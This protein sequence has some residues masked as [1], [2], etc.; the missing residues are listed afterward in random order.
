VPVEG[1]EYV[2]EADQVLVAV[3]QMP[4]TG[5]LPAE[6]EL[7]VSERGHVEAINEFGVTPLPDV[8]V[9]GDV[10]GRTGS[11]IEA[12]ASGR[13]AALAVDCFL[14]G[15]GYQEAVRRWG[16]SVPVDTREVLIRSIEREPAGRIGPPLREAEERAGDFEDVE[17]T[18]SEQDAVREASRCLRCGCG[19]GCELCYR[20]CPYFAVKPDGF[21]FRVDEELC[22]GCGLCIERCPNDNIE[23]VPLQ[24]AGTGPQREDGEK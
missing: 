16:E 23:A 6:T 24:A 10:T 12:I 1:G 3:S 18:M 9:A 5:D 4:E 13:R 8:F 21:M 11:V 19:V 20:I 17:L 15:E 2:L 7:E 14:K 22:A